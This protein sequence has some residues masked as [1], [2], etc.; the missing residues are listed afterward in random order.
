M[1]NPVDKAWHKLDNAAKIFPS[2]SGNSDARVFRFSCELMEDVDG[3]VLQSALDRTIDDFPVFQY[4]MKRGMFWYYL[5]QSDLRPIV[6]KENA[7]PCSTIYLDRKTLL[8]D[9]TWYRKRINLEVYHVL[10][11]GTGA[12]QFLKMLVLHYLKLAHPVA[13]AEISGVDYDA[14]D[15]QKM[16]DSFD[17]YYDRSKKNSK[18]KNPAAYQLKG[19]KEAEWRLKIIEGSVSTKELLSKAREYGATATV[20]ITALLMHSIYDEMKVRDRKQPVIITVPVNLRNFFDSKSTRNFF[21][22]VDIKYDFRRN[23]DSLEDIIAGVKE[24]FTER[25]NEE[26]LQAR[27]NKYLSFEKNILIRLVP[28]TIKNMYMHIAYSFAAREFTAAVSNVGRVDMPD[29]AKPYI[30]LFDVICSTE[31]LQV[32]IC[33]YEDTMNISITS[34]FV[35][36]DIQRNFFRQLTGMG[37]AVEISAD[38]S[39]KKQGESSEIL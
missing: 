13:M 10:S 23:G 35:S 28:L 31:K 8:F 5:E 32:C 19:A 1:N 27:L 9:V 18:V 36:T 26:Y 15:A 3:N 34:P 6:H 24:G 25:L 2:T 7:P 11:D 20:L 38:N 29:E 30:K 17:K 16:T 22:I 39:N 37:I 12:L 33:S 21:S 14:S 4:V